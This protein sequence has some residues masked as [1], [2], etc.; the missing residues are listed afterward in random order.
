[1]IRKVAIRNYRLFG[2][3]DLDLGPGMNIL[4]GNNDTGKSTLIEAINLALTGRNNGRPLSQE[5]NPYLLNQEA[6]SEYLD[7][8]NDGETT[9]PPELVIEVYLED[10]DAAEIL[11]G[12]NN[13]YGEDACGIRIQAKLS[14]EF[15]EEYTKFIVDQR[16][17]VKSRQRS[18]VTGSGVKSRQRS[19]VKSRLALF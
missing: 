11:R 2:R 7:A 1:M 16:S 12:T 5:L 17:G 4:V 10:Y 19:G 8:L 18:G 6:T 14:P 9:I 13:L 3:F 15:A